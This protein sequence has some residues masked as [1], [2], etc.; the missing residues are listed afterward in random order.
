MNNNDLPMMDNLDSKLTHQNFM[1]VVYQVN[2][3]ACLLEQKDDGSI[4]AEYVTPSF[5]RMM[6]CDTQEEALE[7]MDGENLFKNTFPEDRQILRDLLKH[8]V[9]ADGTP[10]ITVRK[11]TRK[12]NLIWCAIHYAFIDDYDRHYIY[13]TFSDVTR[14]KRYEE[15]LQSSSKV[16]ALV[17]DQPDHHQREDRRIEDLYEARLRKA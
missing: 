13:A 8:H 17:H 7:L 5:V 10:D 2:N 15:Q 3:I 1:Q 6:E 14:L 16:P 9:G 4:S 11:T 12:G